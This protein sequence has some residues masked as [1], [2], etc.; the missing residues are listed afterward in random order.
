M[1]VLSATESDPPSH[2]DLSVRVGSLPPSPPLSFP[3]HLIKWARANRSDLIYHIF[4]R[5]FRLV[6]VKSTRF[7]TWTHSSLH[8]TRTDWKGREPPVGPVITVTASAP[9]SP[10]SHNKL[11]L[12]QVNH[13]SHES[14]GEEIRKKQKSHDAIWTRVRDF[15]RLCVFPCS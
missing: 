14:S 10:R 4:P 5:P 12:T 6:N 7:P 3:L 9:T 15:L 11:Y 13:A 1:R 8:Q 2:P